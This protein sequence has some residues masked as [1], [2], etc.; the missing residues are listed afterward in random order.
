[1]KFKDFQP[2]NSNI[3]YGQQ[4]QQ[5]PYYPPQQYPQQYPQH[6]QQQQ[7]QYNFSQQPTTS[8]VLVQASK[9]LSSGLVK[10]G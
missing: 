9:S 7:Q 6:Y 1:M 4:Y 10:V 8:M 2:N 5:Q 3:Q